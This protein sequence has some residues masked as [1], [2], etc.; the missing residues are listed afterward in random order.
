MINISMRDPKNLKEFSPFAPFWVDFPMYK[1]DH[2]SVLICIHGYNTE[3]KEAQEMGANLDRFRNG[4]PFNLTMLSWPSNGKALNYT[5]DRWDAVEAG[6]RL[7]ALVTSLNF[8]GKRVYLLAHSMGNYVV[9]NALSLLKYGDVYRWYSLAGDISASECEPNGKWGVQCGK[10]VFAHFYY[11]RSDGV[12]KWISTPRHLWNRRIGE[13]GLPDNHPSNWYNEDARSRWGVKSHS[14]YFEVPAI[15][16][17]I[18]DQ[19]VREN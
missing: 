10:T 3:D 2:K 6:K 4:R 16:E 14:G 5:A 9:A 13:V 17:E 15:F 19:I 8:Q 1:W 11:T 18:F 7:A 12:L